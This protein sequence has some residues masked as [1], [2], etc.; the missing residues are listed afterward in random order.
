M[1][2]AEQ[3]ATVEPLGVELHQSR[4]KVEQ[5]DHEHNGGDCDHTHDRPKQRVIFRHS[6]FKS[7]ADATELNCK[8]LRNFGSGRRRKPLCPSAS[9]RARCG[10]A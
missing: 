8:Q 2:L 5:G 4:Q 3:Y 6:H 7:V 10:V 9:V 1:R